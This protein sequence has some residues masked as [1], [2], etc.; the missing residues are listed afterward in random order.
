MPINFDSVLGVHAK[1]LTIYARRAELLASN[2][3]NSDTPGYKAKDIDFKAALNA[4]L[5]QT[6]PVKTYSTQAASSDRLSLSHSNHI[7]MPAEDHVSISDTAMQT[8]YRVPNHP[9]LDGN[10]VDSQMEKSAFAENALR[11]QASLRFLDGKFK[12][13]IAALK[14]E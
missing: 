11:Y 10:T 13:L 12:G 3:A 4:S 8:M 14:G 2:L 6:S 9:S 5:Q 1:A 7:A